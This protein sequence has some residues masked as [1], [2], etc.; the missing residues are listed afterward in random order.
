MARQVNPYRPGF[1]QHPVLLAGRGAVLAG[2]REA[3]DVAALDGRMPRPLIL[4][5]VRGVG[6]TVALNEI[7]NLA[8]AEHSWVGV[9]VEVKPRTSFLAEL[10]DRLA[11]AE[12]LLTQ[13]PPAGRMQLT[14]ARVKAGAF[15]VGGEAG[16]TRTSGRP[17]A[18]V[19]ETALAETTSAAIE[20]ASGLVLTLD[21]VHLATRE[22]LATLTAALQRHVPDGWPIVVAVAGL[23][24]LRDPRSSVTYLERGEW[25]ELGPLGPSDTLEALT[26]PASLAGRPM[27][28]QA[29]DQLA[30]ASG[31][32]PYAVQVFGH[33]AWRASTGSATITADHAGQATTAAQA[34]LAGGLYAGRWH[35]ASRKQREYL[36]AMAAQLADEGAVTHADVARR[37]GKA[38]AALSYLRARLLAKGTIFSD[39]RSLRFLVPGMATWIL[40]TEEPG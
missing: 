36:T 6:K 34:D 33:H 37:L 1:A 40:D 31:G 25:H 16:F 23:P 35:D 13:T 8:A 29:A 26:R 17:P 38:P 39:G 5:G 22:D 2:A 11:A 30:A 10:V 4:V 24:S 15:G 27:D 32:Y 21:E 19:V 12:Q 7:S 28:S 9:H 18:D 14:E 20:R 3:L